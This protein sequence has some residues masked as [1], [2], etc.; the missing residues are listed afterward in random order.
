MSYQE[1]APV[2]PVSGLPVLGVEPEKNAKADDVE[3]LHEKDISSTRSN[4]FLEQGFEDEASRLVDGEHVITTGEDVSRYLLTTRDDG[5]PALTFRS[6]VLGTV[7]AGLG[8]AMCQRLGQ[9]SFLGHPWSKA[10]DYPGLLHF[11][12]SSTQALSGSKSINCGWRE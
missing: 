5:D 9:W 8:A 6:L 10:R 4:S 3:E 11:F 1:K 7:F 12:E 2:S